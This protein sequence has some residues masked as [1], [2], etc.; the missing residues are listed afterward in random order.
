MLHKDV[1][2]FE[3]KKTVTE[4]QVEL[5]GPAPTMTCENGGCL[6]DETLLSVR[7]LF[8]LHVFWNTGHFV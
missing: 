7:C 6:Q 5:G 8:M 1:Q 3:L 2:S 4:C